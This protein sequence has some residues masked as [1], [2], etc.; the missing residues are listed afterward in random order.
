MSFNET[1]IARD[2]VFCA[3]IAL[4][5][6]NHVLSPALTRRTSEIICLV[7]QHELPQNFKM[8]REII[9]KLSI[10]RTGMSLAAALTARKRTWVIDLVGGVS[11]DVDIS[12][13]V[14]GKGKGDG[15]IGSRPSTAAVVEDPASLVTV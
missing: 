12:G 3:I 6:G 13:C 11:S 10:L 5:G 14:G 2:L 4:N 15:I 9:Q 1:R 7:F 8:S